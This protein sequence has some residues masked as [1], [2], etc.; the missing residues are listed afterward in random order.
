MGIANSCILSP[1]EGV[2]VE[3]ITVNFLENYMQPRILSRNLTVALRLGQSIALC[4]LMLG[5]ALPV[6]AAP[7]ADGPSPLHNDA[8]VPPRVPSQRLVEPSGSGIANLP[9]VAD[10]PGYYDTS[11]YMIGTV[12]VGLIL[13][14]SNGATDASTEDWTDAEKTTVLN[15]VQAALDWLESQA[16]PA[17]QLNFVLDTAAPRVVPTK[18][19][20]INRPQSQ[21][22]LWIGDTLANM[23]YPSGDYFWDRSYAYINDLRT[24]YNTDWAFTIF[25]ADSSNDPDG[26][27]A[28]GYFFAYSYLGGPFLVMNYDNANWG[29]DKMN[30]VAA[31]EIGHIFMAGD[32]YVS[33]GCTQTQRYGYL[34]VLNSWCKN[35]SPS[36][37]KGDYILSSVDPARAQFGWRD[38]D[39]DGI[40]DLIDAPPTVTLPAHVPDPT[41][42][43]SFSYSGNVEAN[44]YPHFVGCSPSYYCAERDITLQTVSEIAFQVDG[45]GWQALPASDGAFNE[46]IEEFTFPVGPLSNGSHIIE[47]RGTSTFGRNGGTPATVS[48]TA[49]DPV[50]IGT[51]NLPGPG[52]YDDKHTGWTY[53][54]TWYNSPSVSAYGSSFR[55]SAKIGNSTSFSFEGSRFT[56][57]YA[58][59][60]FYGNLDIYVDNVKVTTLSQYSTTTKWQQKYTS[61]TYANTAHT[62]RLA[63]ASGM[64]VNVDAIQ[65][66][67]PPDIDPPAA[68]TNLATSPGTLNGSVNLTWSAPAEDASTG[69]G[70][71]ASY[72]VRYSLNPINDANWGA[73]SAV[74]SGLPA[75]G[76]PGASQ[77]MTVSGLVPGVTYYFAV[78][79]QD[80]EPNLGGMSNDPVPT[81]SM[82]PAPL[83]AGKYDDKHANWVLKGTWLNYPF[84]A[85]YSSS[86]RYSSVINN[87]AAFV[88]TGTNFILGYA[89]GLLYGNLDV[90]VDGIYTATINQKASPSAL[91]TYSL[92]TP[93]A[94]GQ[95]T[96]QFVHRS[97]MRVNIDSISITP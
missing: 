91:R 78:R 74:T 61:P 37:M 60:V 2:G 71:V 34:G 59:Y 47:T 45:G 36:L 15:E 5:Q 23:G 32:Q 25:V 88:F 55:Y 65:V 76:V 73:A 28:N 69:T 33:S 77:Q 93:L 6:V 16:P 13:P 63:H 97:G 70:T 96:V 53:T 43:T 11:E 62:V 44:P 46:Q 82:S 75:A 89:V 79:A 10:L 9:G 57:S 39:S 86:L 66:Y 38:S 3:K 84:A 22:N 81:T 26:Y 18:Y 12:A 20:P 42:E 58:M 35:T 95:H 8:L 7:P 80:E 14:E 29:I 4:L 50:T 21:E 54:G 41:T 49:S 67:G 40:P 31:H 52:M 56:L 92:P 19:E 83:G 24:Q 51:T 94:A 72:L 87:S 1:M 85:A 30:Q 64:R 27:F 48:A 68:I 17:A 90:Y